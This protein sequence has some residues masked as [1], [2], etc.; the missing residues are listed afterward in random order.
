MDAENS[1]N[2]LS[3]SH[4]IILLEAYLLC[5]NSPIGTSKV[6]TPHHFINFFPLLS[7]PFILDIL[8][9]HD[10]S[11]WLFLLSSCPCLICWKSVLNISLSWKSKPW[12]YHFWVTRSFP[13][14]SIQLQCLASI[15]KRRKIPQSKCMALCRGLSPHFSP[16]PG[17][18]LNYHHPWHLY[19]TRTS[20]KILS[21]H[22]LL[23]FSQLCEVVWEIKSFPGKHVSVLYQRVDYYLCL[24]TT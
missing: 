13:E 19:D 24:L 6:L 10:F 7:F 11:K 2:K 16:L 8:F 5:C 22:F 15:L 12:L 18:E 14:A 21:M 9:C 4:F 1:T 17:T 20:L 3:T 23:W